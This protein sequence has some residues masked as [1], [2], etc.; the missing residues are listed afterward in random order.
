[1][2]RK[3]SK[4]W[5]I[6]EIDATGV[7]GPHEIELQNISKA[8]YALFTNIER[9]M[10]KKI[11]ENSLGGKIENIGFNEDW[12]ITIEMFPAVNI[13]LVYTY[14]GDEFGD[15]IE[16]EF[17]FLL[18]GERVFWIPGEDSATYIDLIM[19]LLENKIKN[20]EP[21]EKQ[22]DT[23]TDL[24][25]KVLVQRR[26][27][28]KFLRENDKEGL[29]EFLGAKVWK[30]IEGWKIKKEIFP[31]IFIELTW[32]Q[33]NLLDISYSGTNLQKNISSYHVELIGIFMINHILRYI[34]ITNKDQNLP[35][36]CFIMFS[37]LFTKQMDW[38]HR[39]R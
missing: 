14:Y 2:I 9:N 21:F 13:H 34:T 10:L 17:K 30:T 31:E 1:M 18:S 6:G 37:R 12:T 28:F 32:N 16:A 19:D 7:R 8:K 4:Y 25:K 27:P 5:T 35:D 36:I 20:K 22:F 29:T 38:Q 23:K 3:S 26:E 15:D 11:V 39:R 33:Q 24:M